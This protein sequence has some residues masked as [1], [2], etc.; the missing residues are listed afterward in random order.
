MLLLNL[1]TICPS[2]AK[3]GSL[4]NMVLSHFYYDLYSSKLSFQP[5]EHVPEIRS[6]ILG[7]SYDCFL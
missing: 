5:S 7:I 6:D 1:N 4:L 2:P 3:T